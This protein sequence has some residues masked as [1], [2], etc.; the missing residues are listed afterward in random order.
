MKTA[1]CIL[2]LFLL[3]CIAFA[4]KADTITVHQR[5]NVIEL[6]VVAPDTI[7]LINAITSKPEKKIITHPP[8]PLSL[9]GM[10]IYTSDKPDF[11]TSAAR[12]KIQECLSAAFQDIRD[13]LPMGAYSYNLPDLVINREGKIA[14]HGPNSFVVFG[15]YAID[16]APQ[17]MPD[18]LKVYIEKMFDDALDEVEL[19]PLVV[20][21]ERVPFLLDITMD[22]SI[23][24]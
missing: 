3:P 12:E 23:S 18:T 11:I 1:A 20:D 7:K 17:K 10:A 21:G 19:M 4:G 6:K 16:N 13:S 8:V 2:S 15:S 24:Q 9:N 5:N 22:I 14:Y